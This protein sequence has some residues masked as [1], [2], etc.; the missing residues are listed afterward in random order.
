[1]NDVLINLKSVCQCVK[2]DGCT[3]HFKVEHDVG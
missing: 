3:L 1:M 2:V